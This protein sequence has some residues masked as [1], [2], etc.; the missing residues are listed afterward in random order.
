M[1]ISTFWITHACYLDRAPNSR[2]VSAERL[3]DKWATQKPFVVLYGYISRIHN[4]YGCGVLYLWVIAA[5][6]GVKELG[7]LKQAYCEVTAAVI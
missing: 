4:G 5:A 3:D 7:V 1:F 2:E 6:V